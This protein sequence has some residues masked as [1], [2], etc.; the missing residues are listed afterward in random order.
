MKE[1]GPS[2]FDYGPTTFKTISNHFYTSPVKQ[3]AIQDGCR[4]TK[5]VVFS[6]KDDKLEDSSEKMFFTYKWKM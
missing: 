6:S 2:I 3:S 5:E 1:K 4:I